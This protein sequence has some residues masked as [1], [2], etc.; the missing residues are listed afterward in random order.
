VGR[1]EGAACGN[2]FEGMAARIERLRN[3]GRIRDGRG[4][5]RERSA[6]GG[7]DD[8]PSVDESK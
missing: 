2:A 8:I 1:D 7:I 5:P 6:S 4:S 3:S